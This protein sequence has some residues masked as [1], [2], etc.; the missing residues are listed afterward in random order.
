MKSWLGNLRMTKKVLLAPVTAI[1]FLAI[2]GLVSSMGFFK[3][4]AVLDDIFNKR[5]TYYKS[6]AD[7]II[8]L[9]TVH[10]NV[11]KLMSWTSSGYD[12]QK[13]DSF[14]QEQFTAIKKA[15]TG[16]QQFMKSGGLAKE[17]RELL[18]QTADQLPKYQDMLH[19]VLSMDVTTASILMNQADD[20][21]QAIS[22]NLNELIVLE[23]SLSK[24]QYDF[25]GKTFVTVLVASALVFLAAIVLSIGMAF[26]MKNAILSPIK[27]TV[28]TIEIVAQGD[29]TRRMNISSN[30]EVGEMAKHFNGFV[31]KLHAAITKVADSS[32]KVSSAARILDS[33]SEQIAAG[34]EEAAMQV[35]SVASASEEMSKTTSEIARNCVTAANTSE[36]AVNLASTGENT[37]KET[38]LV[39]NDISDG[40]RSSAN[41]I[42]DL[43]KRSDQI[44]E[45]VGLINDVADQ[46]NLLALNAAIEAARAGEHG[47]GFAVV[48]DEVRKLAER[49]SVATKEIGE[50][51]RAMQT[52]TKKA[53]SS[54]QEDV[55]K[56]GQGTD[57]ASKSGKALEQIRTEIG[58]VAEEIRQIAVSSEEETQVTNEIAASVQQISEV[59]HETAG[60]IQEN[61]NA[62]SQLA[63]LS[64]DLE[65]MVGQF[66]L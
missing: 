62:S 48:A 37:T 4:K 44:G 33:A 40:V 17:E 34:M 15:T 36:N 41:I 55:R 61:A 12:K 30:D 65:S 59:M 38:I 7:V 35:G 24:K 54:M 10:A 9:K 25:A 31:D 63:G 3:Q 19:Q 27:E 26:V 23:N 58:R 8:D 43:G 32:T 45:I 47:R 60:K 1:L 66:R 53:I 51:I 49:T 28:Q 13:I 5:F 39:M 56:V 57:E 64:R 22:K 14:T 6:S 16:I 11:Y 52:D 29:L 46:T 21:F 18:R 2:F 20:L 50:T 42:I